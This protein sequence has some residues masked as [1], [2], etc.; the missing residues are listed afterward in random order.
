MM[1][2]TSASTR[3][4][5]RRIIRLAAMLLVGIAARSALAED[6]GAY[7][8]IPVGEAGIDA[9]SGRCGNDRGDARFRSANQRQRPTRNG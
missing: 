5:S 3:F 8:I 1:N 9:R 2:R 7:A 4:E 6:S